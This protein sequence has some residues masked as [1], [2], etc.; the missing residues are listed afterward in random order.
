MKNYKTRRQLREE[1]LRLRNTILEQR[2]DKASLSDQV[3]SWQETAHV[4]RKKYED[5]LLTPEIKA[6]TEAAFSR[7]VHHAKAQMQSYFIASLSEMEIKN[8][9]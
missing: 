1:V 9:S 3:E 7:G 4:W 5:L 8:E 6:D 2:L